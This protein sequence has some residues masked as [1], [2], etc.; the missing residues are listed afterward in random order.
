MIDTDTG[1][2]WILVTGKHTKDDGTELEIS[3]WQP[4]DE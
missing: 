2:T 3:S 1:K 4:F